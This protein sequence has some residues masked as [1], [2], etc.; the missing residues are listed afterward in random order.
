MYSD[1]IILGTVQFGLDYGINN[2]AG[3]P[4][5]EQVFSML[6]L[7]SE[8]GIEILD[9]A[10]TYGNA[11]DIL[12]E[13]NKT[14]PDVFKI[15]TKFKAGSDSLA[16][17]LER[18]LQ[19]LSISSIN[20][21]FFHS[22][23]DFQQFPGLLNE[24]GSLKEKGFIKK[25]GV[26]VYGNDEF[27]MAINTPEVDV[28]QFPFNLLDNRLQRGKLM[29]L[30]KEKGKELQIRSVFMQ[31][32]FFMPDQEIPSKLAPLKPY[33]EKASDAAKAAGLSMESLALMYAFHQPE[34]DHIIIGVDN[35]EQLNKNL[36]ACQ[37]KISA[38]VAD[39]IN[40]IAVQETDLLYPK[41]WN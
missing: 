38:E 13:F 27:E 36:N 30:A 32:L 39:M 40:Q 5:I 31:G 7:A 10:D 20:I 14:H 1:K 24:F 19:V 2:P 26:S 33:L 41:N 6:E 35:P 15:N 21:Y 25:A 34:I 3:K 29:T 16:N 11:S 28:I 18:S 9:T 22:F 23:N 8:R 17:Q 4:A 12:G 37:Q